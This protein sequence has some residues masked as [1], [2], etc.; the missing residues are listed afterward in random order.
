MPCPQTLKGI[1][2]DC[3]PSMGGVRRVL[4]CNFDDVQKIEE[5]EGVISAITM[6]MDAKFHVYNFKPNTASMTPAPQ[7][8]QENGTTFVQ[9]NVV[10]MFNRM[11]TPKRIEITALMRADLR[12]IV[13][14]N[15]GT[16]WLLGK[17]E[18]V[19]AINGDGSGTGTARADRNG[20][21]ITLQDNS[22]EYPY[23]VSSEIV[24]PLIE[25]GAAAA[26]L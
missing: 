8:N 21:G 26:K 24:I 25:G 23:E 13:E 19:V 11:D 18:P 6:N 14:D 16:Y 17:D 15:N 22:L 2:K 3:Q 20:Y 4:L 9:T 1:V 10:M 7:I 5:T 12:A